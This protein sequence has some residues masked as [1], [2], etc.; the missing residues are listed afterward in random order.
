[1][2][3]QDALNRKLLT[4][5]DYV[6][7]EPI[8]LTNCEKEPIHIPGY[9]QPHGVLLAINPIDDFRIAQCSRNTEQL[10]GISAES[11]LG[12]RLEELIGKTQFELMIRRDLQAIAT[13]DLQYINL[14]ISVANEPIEFIGILHESEGLILLELEPISED[15]VPFTDDFE[16]IQTFFSRMKRT[17]N[18]VEASQVAC[19]LVKDILGYDRVMLY[20]FDDQ[21]NGKVIAEAKEQGLESF[22]GHHYPASD[23]PRQA[24]EL[25]LR[26]WLRTI[27]DVG[28]TPVEIIPTVQP[29]T[30]KPLN[31]SLSVLRSVSPLHIEYL[32][33]MGVGATTT[34]SLIHDNQLWGLITCHHYS[35]KYVSHRTRNLCNFLGSFFS[36]ELYQRQQLDDYQTELRLRILSARFTEIFIGNTDVYQVLEQL[37]TEEQ[38]LLDLMSATG[39]AVYY[40]DN[41]ML[42]G[43]TPTSKQVME[44]AGWLS[45]QAEDYTYHSSKL[46]AEY[47]PAKAFKDV[48]SGVLYLALSP[49]QQNY[50]MWFRPE[51][52]EI[53]DWAGDPAKAVIQEEDKIRL[54]PR[55]SFE[56]WRQVVE[57]TSYSWKAQELSVLPQLKSIVRKQTDFQLR[58]AKEQA[59]QNARIFRENEER[60]LQLMGHSPVA[61]LSLTTAGTIVYCNSRA[62]TLFGATRPEELL[63]VEIYTLASDDSRMGLK[64]QIK[65]MDQNQAQLVSGS[66]WFETLDGK[67]IELEY[68]LAAIHQGRKSSIMVILREGTPD[69]GPDRVYSDV[70]NQ[71]QSY[72]TTDPLTELPNP[73]TFEKELATDW[74]ECIQNQVFLALLMVD[75]DDFRVYNTLHGLYGGDLCLQ[76]IA[77]ALKIIGEYYG[78]AVSRYGG[79]T[80]ILK[81]KDTDP[82]RT[83][84][85]AEKI[86]Q[87][88]LALSIPKDRTEEDG[89]MTVS[90]GAA[91]LT[92][93]SMLSL[94][95]LT[96]ETEKAMH[97]AKSKG[98]NRVTLYGYETD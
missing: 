69:G 96:D 44:L 30:G 10:L 35:R 38:G 91:C 82:D 39:A 97:I 1:M 3:E 12:Q 25:Y 43:T 49:G 55:K 24:R 60:Y 14:T 52:V 67:G 64:E 9:I 16:W 23:I 33:N 63:Q 80:F 98:K 65:R 18:R 95:H 47:D 93:T 73:A 74:E 70:L 36:N 22:L 42:Y 53:V 37:E 15:T 79:G 78:A 72:V 27:V 61:F 11:L 7:D 17:E 29:L 13:P 31:L 68:M 4:E 58:Q 40:Q 45:A 20:E 57:G 84:E 66:G 21:W 51:V 48:A 90:V 76:W 32:H 77:D 34:I 19:E 81:I 85:V 8:D 54:S 28:Y 2:T 62:E 88:V 26:N 46:S 86:R 75:I 92:P 6:T 41:L 56:K 83:Y 89:F 59:I 94:T 5:G 71:L 87:G 50:V